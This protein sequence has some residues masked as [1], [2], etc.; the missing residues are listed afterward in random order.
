MLLLFLWA[1]NLRTIHR[2][3][4]SEFFLS[5]AQWTIS[6]KICSGFQ[7]GKVYVIPVSCLVNRVKRK[8]K[9]GPFWF[10]QLLELY[11]I[12]FPNTC[13]A[14]PRFCRQ[15]LKKIVDEIFP[16]NLFST[17]TKFRINMP[18]QTREWIMVLVTERT[19]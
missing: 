4:A 5:S 15:T 12:R 13:F 18:C 6:V 17:C 11:K 10:L 1:K 3:L 2:W 16:K 7:R 9:D 14:P 19:T 8:R